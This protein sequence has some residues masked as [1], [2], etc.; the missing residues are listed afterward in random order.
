MFAEEALRCGAKV[1]LL[2]ALPVEE[3]IVASVQMPSGK[4]LP[5]FHALLEQ[6]EV[7]CQ[8]DRLGPPQSREAVFARTNLW[9]LNTARVE[10]PG[11]SRLYALLVWDENPQGDG[12]G[13]TADFANRASSTG[14]TLSIINQKSA[15]PFI[16]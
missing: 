5:R 8:D 2:L 15:L 12:P 14:A 4:W 13:G 6:C 11:V 3:F 9:M 7:V 16:P 1:R 10:A